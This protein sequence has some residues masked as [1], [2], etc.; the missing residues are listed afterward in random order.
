MSSP[1]YEDE[2]QIWTENNKLDRMAFFT[3]CLYG[4][5]IGVALTAGLMLLVL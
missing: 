5:L 2:W 1:S 4:F 3:G